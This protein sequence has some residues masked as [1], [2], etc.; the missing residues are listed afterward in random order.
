MKSKLY[1][2]SLAL[3][4]CS[5]SFAAPTFDRQAEHRRR[6]DGLSLHERDALSSRGKTQSLTASTDYLISSSPFGA[7]FTQDNSD[8]AQLD[9][10]D[11]LAIWNDNRLGAEKIFFQKLSA[12]GTKIGTNTLIA[13][14]T[15]GATITDP[16]LL[17]DTAGRF[18]LIYRN[19][20]SGQI[21]GS[22]FT[23]AL[24][25]IG[26]EFQIS[27]SS[28]G[29]Y[30]GPFDAAV[31]P[32]GRIVV[33]WENYSASG[34]N[35]AMRLYDAAGTSILGPATVNSDASLSSR[36]T[37]SVAVDP[38]SGF[39]VAWED[40]RL[41][42]ADIYARLFSGAGTAVGPDFGIVSPIVADSQQ[43]TPEVAFS[44]RDQYAIGWID[45]RAGQEV[46]LQAYNAT[47]GLVGANTLISVANPIAI[48]WNLHFSINSSGDLLAAW[49][50]TVA[51]SSILV[52]RFTTAFAPV[53]LPGAANASAIGQRWNPGAAF[54]T[55]G[56]Y[57][58]CWS[59]F[60]NNHS[61]IAFQLFNSGGTAQLSEMILNDDNFGAPKSEPVIVATSDWFNLIA[62]TS[63]SSDQGDIFASCI[64][65]G[66]VIQISNTKVNQ[67]ASG[68]LQSEPAIGFSATQAFV[69]WNDSRD[70][71]GIPGQRI[72]GRFCT[73]SGSFSANE[74]MVSDSAQTGLKNSP[75]IAMTP[76]GKGLVA[77]IDLRGLS[78]QVWGRWLT[79][80]G[81][82]DGAEVQ[83][84][85]A[86]TDSSCSDLSAGVDLAGRFYVTWVDRRATPVVRGHWYNADGTS[87]GYI[88]YAPAGALIDEL[89]SAI[90]DSGEVTVAYTGNSSG[91]KLFVAAVN[92][93]SVQ[94]LAPTQL[95]DDNAA[96][97][98]EPDISF[99]ES[100]NQFAIAWVDRRTGR[101][102]IECQILDANRTGVGANQAVSSATPEY[103]MHPSV[104]L[105]DGRAWF[106]W[107]DP[108]QDGQNIWA[109]MVLYQPTG[110]DDQPGI[111]PATFSL[112]QN[113]PNPFNPTTE[114][115][116][117]LPTR[118]HATLEV[119]NVIG[120][121]VNVLA[122]GV[123]AAGEHRIEWD[124]KSQSGNA[125]A[126]G[127]YLY[128]LKTTEFTLSRK[129]V[130]VK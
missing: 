61:D 81:A 1:V 11:W 17:P 14:S 76:A 97:P 19:A 51:Q 42:N 84:S 49:D 108:R 28:L 38:Q 107:A 29:A 58:V 12:A 41:G 46:Y 91:Q 71:L 6:L 44:P 114:I 92:R 78:P 35:I 27:D 53:G 130:L 21:L 122:N 69:A 110:T 9:S 79:N 87:G 72:Y 3:L 129:M 15:V 125:V 113:Y 77:W 95:N 32:D 26:S 52:R 25:P 8:V 80:A 99:S 50:A 33:V 73:L 103:M 83:I 20:T 4:F 93:A 100:T 126:S 70:V 94:M 56:S 16:L 59:E 118:G 112:Q 63:K 60:Q 105:N 47:T 22:R 115:Q 98:T 128:R 101:R 64:S 40:Y 7:H 127:I 86:G 120:E 30:A 109:S 5:A 39:V 90:N 121:R 111:V 45:S 88:D 43:Y 48:N 57:A 10:G 66:N 104:T 34:T 54:S 62:F 106:V 85:L 119:F 18:Y 65:N 68:A 37:P 124:G 89:S 102:A 117:S 36:W 116:F 55:T 82:L 23:D 24:A 13:G 74:F 96:N 67:D 2:T 75:K 31:Y 123:F